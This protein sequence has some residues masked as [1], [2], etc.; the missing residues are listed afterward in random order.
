MEPIS[1]MS[2]M[3]P[4]IRAR[5]KALGIDQSTLADLAGVSR[6]AVSEVERG[7]ETIRFDVLTKICSALGLTIELS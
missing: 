4:K 3:S 1:Y 6:K 2:A 5:R 7:K